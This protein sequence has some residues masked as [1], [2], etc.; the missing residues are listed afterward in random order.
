MR[1]L[2]ITSSIDPIS[3]INRT[4]RIA[5]TT[6]HTRRADRMDDLQRAGDD[7][8]VDISLEAYSFEA[9]QKAAYRLADRCTVIFH[10]VLD[11]RARLSFATLQSADDLEQVKRVFFREA[12]DYTLRDRIAAETN[13]LRNLIL[14]HAFSRTRLVER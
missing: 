8:S 10:E 12:L 1:P 2:A 5:L 14:A 3:R 4:A 13:P 11:G 9:L 7:A 6:R